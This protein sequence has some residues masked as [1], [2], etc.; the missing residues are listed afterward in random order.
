MAD[1]SSNWGDSEKWL[2]S[3][4]I[5]K[6]EKKK[7]TGENIVVRQ[8]AKRGSGGSNGTKVEDAGKVL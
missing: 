1:S 8:G 4:C 2:N 6:S 3:G 5:L 7:R